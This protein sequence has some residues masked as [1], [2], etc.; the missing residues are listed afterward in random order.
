MSLALAE[1]SSAS[2]TEQGKTNRTAAEE[3]KRRIAA[4]G[5][6]AD[7]LDKDIYGKSTANS[8][9]CTSCNKKGV[10]NINIEG[11]SRKCSECLQLPQDLTSSEEKKRA[12]PNGPPSSFV[13]QFSSSL[14]SIQSTT[15]SPQHRTRPIF[16]KQ[17]KSRKMSKQPFFL[18][19]IGTPMWCYFVLTI[20]FGSYFWLQMPAYVSYMQG[21]F[22]TVSGFVIVFLMPFSS[23]VI[24]EKA[25]H[26]K[27]ALPSGYKMHKTKMMPHQMIEKFPDKFEKRVK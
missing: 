12:S 15:N 19:A 24:K 27:M 10:M 2:L 20:V 26:Q 4:S 9:Y 7:D 6:S 8:I 21:F 3:L 16:W 25:G 1:Q 11:I 22:L 17:E 13:P 23:Y 5:T 18:R 14:V